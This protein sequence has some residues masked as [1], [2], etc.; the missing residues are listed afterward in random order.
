MKPKRASLL[1]ETLPNA[2][3]SSSAGH[4]KSLS[5]SGNLITSHSRK[6]SK[7]KGSTGG[8]AHHRSRASTSFANAQQSPAQPLLTPTATTAKFLND[9]I[10]GE[11]LPIPFMDFSSGIGKHQDFNALAGWQ[12]GGLSSPATP[13]S[14]AVDKKNRRTSLI[15]G[16]ASNFFHTDVQ[17]LLASVT[18]PTPS[19]LA[20]SLPISI[21]I[22]TPTRSA[23]TG[24]TPSHAR[25]PSRHNR[26]SS[27]SNFR[28][29]I[30]IMSGTGMFMGGLSPGVSSFAATGSSPPLSASPRIGS[31]L[32]TWA[33]DPVKVLEILKERGRLENLSESD[34]IRTRQSA[35]EALEGRL[36]APSEMINLGDFANG[37]LLV[38]PRSPGYTISAP[39]F[40]LTSP[41]PP[42]AAPP[43][44]LGLS[45]NSKRNSWGTLGPVTAAGAK[46]AM[47]LGMLIEEEEEEEVDDDDDILPASS[48]S[49]MKS[50]RTP[51]KGRP[52][53]LTF[54]PTP[55]A[56]TVV[57]DT[58]A[59]AS[60]AVRPMRLSTSSI[61]SLGDDSPATPADSPSRRPA[62]RLLTLSNSPSTKRHSNDI[63]LSSMDSVR[64]SQV[65]G[66]APPALAPRPNMLNR[67]ASQSS[68]RFS[69]QS[70][71]G[72]RP[73]PPMA[74]RGLRSLS[75]GIIHSSLDGPPVAASPLNRS[76]ILNRRSFGV[77]PPTTSAPSAAPSISPCD[78]KRNPIAYLANNTPLPPSLTSSEGP[79]SPRAQ[80]AR[81]PWRTS[82]E[83][84]PSTSPAEPIPSST[85]GGYAFP[86][87]ASHGNFGGF[88]DLEVEEDGPITTPARRVLS[89]ALPRI[90]STDPVVMALQGEIDMLRN[91][92]V[93]DASVHHH[94]VLA[95]EKRAG[96]DA[97]G[98]RLRI[99][100]L[101]RQLEEGRVGRRF[102]V[103]GLS[104]EV[105]QATEAMSD[106]RE[107]RDSLVEDVDGWRNRC[108]TL[109]T[110]AK[111]ERD[112]DPLTKAQAKLSG[113]MRDQIYNLVEAL[114]RERNLH[115][116]TRQELERNIIE[117][118]A[119]P[120]I[121][122]GE[123]A[124]FGSRG[125][126]VKNRSRTS[127]NLSPSSS[128][129]QSRSGSITEETSVA[130]DF[131]DSPP[132][133]ASTYMA[134][135]GLKGRDRDSDI[136]SSAALGGLDTLAEEDEED[137]DATGR[138][139]EQRGQTIT[140]GVNE[141]DS[142]LDEV[143]LL[144]DQMTE[145]ES[146]RIRLGSGSTDSTENSEA[147]PMT[148]V[149]EYFQ[150][151]QVHRR[152][153]SFVRHWSVCFSTS[154]RSDIF[155]TPAFFYHSFRK[156]RSL[157]SRSLAR[158][159]PFSILDAIL[160]FQPCQ[161]QLHYF[162]LSSARISL[163][164]MS[165]SRIHS[166]TT[167]VSSL[168]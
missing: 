62:L 89:P 146:D 162:L 137:D 138:I 95:V 139:I 57:E 22:G 100:E 91:R 148:P 106:L 5:K 61:A 99:I 1:V 132:H 108:A 158:I 52:L 73:T 58:P 144:E 66:A 82:I 129:G 161:L 135:L 125:H 53:P 69:T 130:T 70:Q 11:D 116:Q 34:P 41:T 15:Y 30:E 28:E 8:H 136:F 83:R 60:F 63:L 153:D 36:S 168:P 164:T 27:V 67:S 38:A 154:V 31:P 131:D 20:D 90:I 48:P 128:F 80:A 24:P 102:E 25:R 4:R 50:K 9:R 46:G 29:S 18:A 119:S 107:E 150:Q 3:G 98:L 79:L 75:T 43:V 59:Q 54:I 110:A 47:D 143:E 155:L 88:G 74:N 160:H 118:G 68:N 140:D 124:A 49:T 64:N 39:P 92:I 16:S 122:D 45:S 19:P 17:Q 134:G 113:E 7:S 165:I 105:E 32:S 157:L 141:R 111:K 76:P 109:E 86:F 55:P 65:L 85:M 117:T 12:I 159:I 81:R 94:E 87:A 104:R 167:L 145:A 97:R 2:T 35:L 6:A 152:S 156:E 40:P 84:P 163:S 51:S 103:E 120:P 127:S 72:E 114:E 42:F 151:G 126:V 77:L 149:K 142:P 23:S 115:D 44:G 14:S 26:Q 10:H 101:E 33:N 147:M 93:Q 112:D 78:S 123:E 121:E 71:P 37:E 166:M 13:P 56:A 133:F 21:E 96:E